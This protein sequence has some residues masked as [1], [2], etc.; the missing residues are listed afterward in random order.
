MPT[1]VMTASVNSVNSR[2]DSICG[3]SSNAR[4]PPP[5][6]GCAPFV[7]PAL[8][9]PDA[10]LCWLDTSGAASLDAQSRPAASNTAAD[11]VL[12]ALACVTHIVVGPANVEHL[13]IRTTDRAV[14]LR[15]HG[16]HAVDQPVVLTL[17]IPGLSRARALGTLLAGLPDL[18]V[19]VPRRPQYSLRKILM[20]DSLIALDG[21]HA[22]ANYRDMASIIHGAPSAHYDWKAGN[23]SIKDHLHRALKLGMALRDGG[24]RM[25][26]A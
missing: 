12:A 10:P 22:G 24:Y 15:L 7:D 21:R 26:I 18:L 1:A 5:S 23:R 2:Q 3:A 8:P 19:A 4:M 14:T 11:I 13:L 6:G 25:L 16:A 9:A 17:Q 20:R